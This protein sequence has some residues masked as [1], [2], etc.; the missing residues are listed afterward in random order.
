ML[1][2]KL[3]ANAG[4]PTEKGMI[5]SQV[6]ENSVTS[7]FLFVSVTHAQ[8]LGER[9]VVTSDLRSTS[10]F[11]KRH[12]TWFLGRRMH[13]FDISEYTTSLPSDT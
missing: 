6:L 5:G 9:V 1:S 2:R 7:L 13:K 8:K 4:R 12:P 11:G 10:G 3:E